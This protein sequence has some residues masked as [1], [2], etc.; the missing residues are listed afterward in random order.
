VNLNR[1]S[2]DCAARGALDM[3]F[4][5]QPFLLMAV[6]S[7]VVFAAILAFVSIEDAIKHRDGD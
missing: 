5:H 3:E 4:M 2:D 6:L 1:S 7:G